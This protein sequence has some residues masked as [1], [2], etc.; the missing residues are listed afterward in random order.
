MFS[1]GRTIAGRLKTL[2]AV[3]CDTPAARA[4]SASFIALAIVTSYLLM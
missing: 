3:P 2:E 1:A 4:T